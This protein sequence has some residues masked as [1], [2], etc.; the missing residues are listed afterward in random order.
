MI[1]RSANYNVAIG[2]TASEVADRL[3]ALKARLVPLVGQARAQAQLGGFRGLPACGAPEQIVE[4]LRTL[5]DRGMSYGIF[6]FPEAT[7]DRSG[8]EPFEREVIPALAG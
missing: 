8:I 1:V 5:Q 2:A 4:N 7:Y 3:Q 6:Y